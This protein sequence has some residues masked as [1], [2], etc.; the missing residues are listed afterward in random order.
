[1]SECVVCRMSDESV[2]WSEEDGFAHR[3]CVIR[4]LRAEVSRQSCEGE[5]KDKA[6]QNICVH[7]AHNPD[8]SRDLLTELLGRCLSIARCI[9]SS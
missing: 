7:T 6:L 2:A 5:R 8:A 9:L 3:A 1:M 4:L